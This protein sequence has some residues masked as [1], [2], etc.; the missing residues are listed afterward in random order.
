[1]K[2]TIEII[3]YPEGSIINVTKEQLDILSNEG[4]VSY[5]DE[6]TEENPNGQ[7]GFNQEDEEKILAILTPVNDKQEQTE[8]VEGF[9]PGE[10]TFKKIGKAL[11]IGLNGYPE[12][13]RDDN[14]TGYIAEIR[15]ATEFFD[16]TQ[17]DEANAALICAAPTLYRDNKELKE[18]LKG[19]EAVLLDG[20]PGKISDYW[21]SVKNLTE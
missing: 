21:F 20:D 11:F 5:D 3:N 2:Q 6:W 17:Q 8:T 9:T 15:K 4:L 10:W 14:H 1:M 16:I 19:F 18:A 12:K 13:V 7:W